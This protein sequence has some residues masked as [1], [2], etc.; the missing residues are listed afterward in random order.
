MWSAYDQIGLRPIAPATG[1]GSV[2]TPTQSAAL[3]EDDVMARFGLDNPLVWFGAFLLVTVG[4]A[5]VA[6]SVRVGKVKVSASAGK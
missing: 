3:T 5:S 1:T 6:G 4:A 2:A